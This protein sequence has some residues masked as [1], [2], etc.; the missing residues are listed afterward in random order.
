M[1]VKDDAKVLQNF[2]VQRKG[3][4]TTGNL[5]ER[6]KR[7]LDTSDISRARDALDHAIGNNMVVAVGPSN[8]PAELLPPNDGPEE[9]EQP[10]PVTHAE[11]GAKLAQM[12][13]Q[14]DSPDELS[15][16][17]ES[18]HWG[19]LAE[20]LGL[21]WEAAD[22]VC[23]FV[24]VGR[25]ELEALDFEWDCSAWPPKAY[26]IFADKPAESSVA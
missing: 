13:A 5:L 4:K 21:G 1:P 24:A 19:H 25:D 2:I 12:R 26:F 22:T 23:S 11:I 17:C 14:S 6:I 16:E 8:Q 20:A 3:Y 15:I 18:S 9:V 7:L 10:E